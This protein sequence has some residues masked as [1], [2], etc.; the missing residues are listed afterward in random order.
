MVY[1]TTIE[2]SRGF[3]RT[4]IMIAC[5]FALV[6]IAFRSVVGLPRD[7]F[8]VGTIL[9]AWCLGYSILFCGLRFGNMLPGRSILA[10]LGRISF[11]VYLLHPFLIAL[12]VFLGASELSLVAFTV[13]ATTALSTVTYRFVEMPAIAIG[14]NVIS[15]RRTTGAVTV[16]D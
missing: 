8:F 15:S 11:S 1:R 2:G 5:I 4:G 9:S 3:W 13:I 12:G 14:R 16:K 10:W 7:E 6:A